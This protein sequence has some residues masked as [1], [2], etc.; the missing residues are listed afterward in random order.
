VGNM[1]AYEIF[2]KEKLD[3]LFQMGVASGAD[4]AV[5]SDI[6]DKLFKKPVRKE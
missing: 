2:Q 6:R 3:E 5:L 1:I 4:V